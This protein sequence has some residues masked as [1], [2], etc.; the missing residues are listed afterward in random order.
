MPV[1]QSL[2]EIMFYCLIGIWSDLIL[3]LVCTALMTN[4]VKH[5]VFILLPM[6]LLW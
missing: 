1:S 2:C 5:H 6:Y 3:V 4:D